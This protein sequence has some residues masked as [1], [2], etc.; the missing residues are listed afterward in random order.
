MKFLVLVCSAGK[1]DP[2]YCKALKQLGTKENREAAQAEPV[3]DGQ[4][5]EEYGEHQENGEVLQAGPVLDS[6][7]AKKNWEKKENKEA[8]RAGP[9][10]NGW[11]AKDRK[12]ARTGT[13]KGMIEMK[14]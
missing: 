9:L 10:P 2:E 14:D 8:A 6:Q 1:K 4:E 3:P 13:G 12:A 7:K 5:A 11:M